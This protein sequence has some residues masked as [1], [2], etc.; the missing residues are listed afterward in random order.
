ME[1]VIRTSNWEEMLEALDTRHVGFYKTT[2]HGFLYAPLKDGCIDSNPKF[3]AEY[4]TK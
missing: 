2:E 4:I 3:V 1:C